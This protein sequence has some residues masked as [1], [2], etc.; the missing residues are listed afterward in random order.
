MVGKEFQ[1]TE[2]LLCADLKSNDHI[3]IRIKFDKVSRAIT[4]MKSAKKFAARLEFLFCLLK[5]LL[6]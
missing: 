5:L 2:I 3:A 6:F 1:P 4:A